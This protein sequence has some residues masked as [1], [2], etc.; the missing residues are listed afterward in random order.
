MA[1]TVVPV[2]TTATGSGAPV[3]VDS[4]GGADYQQVKL[5]GGVIGDT[6]PIGVTSGVPGGTTAG[7]IVAVVPGVSVS[8]QVSGTV[9]ANVSGAVS[10]S[11]MPAV[12]ISGITPV[13][14]AASV[15][16]SGVPVWLNPTQA[17][18][19]GSIVS[20]VL[21]NVVA[22]GA[23]GG[24]V[25]TAPPSISQSG[26]AVWIVGGQGTT[27]NPVVVTGTVAAGAGT[28]VV[29]IQGIVPVT[30]AASVSVSGLPVWLNPTQQVVV[31]G[32]VGH[33]ITGSVNIVSTAIVSLATGGSVTLVGTVG[34]SIIA[35]VSLSGITPVATQTSVSISGVPVWFAPGALVAVSGTGVVTLATGG[36]LATL[37]GTVAVNVV[38]GGA[39]P[40]TTATTQTNVTAQVVWLA[41]TQ[42]VNVTVLSTAVV[43]LATGGSVT[44]VGS[45]GISHAA[46]ASVAATS[47]P[48]L[49][50]AFGVPVWIVG[51]QS[52]T[53]AATP[54]LVTVIAGAPITISG[55]VPVTTAASVSVTGLP[56]WLNPTQAVN[57]GSIVSTVLVN[58]VAGGAGG[59]VSISGVVPVTTA[60]SVSVTGLPVWLNPTQT[61]I[62]GSQLGTAVVTLATGG[63]VTL[64]GTVGA[65]VIAAIS[66]SGI[67]PVTT[68]ASVS[69][70]G[71]PVWLNPSQ[72]IVMGAMSI[73]AIV[74]V[75]TAASVSVT[76]LPVWLNP[77]Q[78]VV[79]SGAVVAVT[80]QS[81]VTGAAIW[82]A[83]TQT[84]VMQPSAGIAFLMRVTSTAVAVSANAY[85]ATVNTGGTL[86]VAG[87]SLY[88]VP[89]GKNLRIA[90]I[91]AAWNSSAVTGG[92]IMFVPVAAGN[93]AS[94]VSGSIPTQGQPLLLLG[95]VSAGVT[96]GLIMG[97]Q[98]DIGAGS[99]IAPF[100][101]ASTAG[102]LV[103]LVI[104][105][106]LF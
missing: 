54:V 37:L 95:I 77:T 62:V 67:V 103:S 40:G 52:V 9:T 105:G 89:A 92:S 82:L 48:P 10:V 41:P 35:A 12:N 1:A 23:G 31:S 14:T 64:V 18:N 43:T 90:M 45:V 101:I 50:S 71:L 86:A 32:L 91:Q 20:T 98:A 63:S 85:L 17:V 88:V 15:S 33:S 4:V 47:G 11:A 34:A 56:V 80:T 46:I 94:L 7:M 25:T 59:V 5:V 36:T 38:A 69:V 76:G 72:S 73:S 84:V 104:S 74:P 13:T 22:G 87:T 8:A 30:T 79:V 99:T 53:A 65:S 100:I 97:A 78:T 81:S 55:I 93:A 39:A 6:T 16:V 57:V 96:A 102:Q 42:T 28:T 3:A 44:L 51:G 2:Q 27:A 83:P 75:T 24:S 68:Q 21:V 19:V 26:Q 70:T 106:Y 60:A 49:F 66:I 29:S 61:V 58:V